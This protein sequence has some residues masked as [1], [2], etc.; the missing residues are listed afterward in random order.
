MGTTAVVRV[1]TLVLGVTTL[2]V[3]MLG[4]GGPGGGMPAPAPRDAPAGVSAPTTP[5]TAAATTSTTAPV[6]PA[7]LA[8][9]LDAPSAPAPPPP[10]PPPA[11]TTTCADALAYLAAHQAPGF[12]DVCGPGSALG[13]YG[14]TCWNI[15]G[16][17]PDGA[18]VIHIA[19]PAPFVY[20]NEAHNSWALQGRQSGIDPYGQGSPDER[21]FCDRLR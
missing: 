3:M 16:R 11:V 4:A 19:C 21:A 10:P 1:L 2:C 12:V 20:M 17:C 6:V 8:A 5:T 14:Y 18:K 7:V 9:R 13:R 15:P